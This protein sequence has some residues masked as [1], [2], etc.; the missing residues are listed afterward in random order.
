M[1]LIRDTS[2]ACSARFG[3]TTSRSVPSTRNRTIE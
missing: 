2:A 3:R 1:I